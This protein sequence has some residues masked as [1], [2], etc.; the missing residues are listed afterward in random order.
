MTRTLIEHVDTELGRWLHAMR[1]PPADLAADVAMLW[2]GDGQTHYRR[3]RILPRG[4]VHLLINLGPRQFLVTAAGERI[5]FDDFWISG[6]QDRYL[7]TEAP[8]GACL[9]GVAFAPGGAWPYLPMP[10]NVLRGFNGE[11]AAVLGDGAMTLRQRLL[12][13]DDVEARFVLVEDWLRRQRRPHRVR[14]AA[15]ASALQAFSRAGTPRI[16]AL[17]RDCG[18]S[19]RRLGQLFDREVGLSPKVWSRL[20]RF[21]ACLSAMRDGIGSACELADRFGYADQAHMSREVRAFSGYAP[22]ELMA[23]PSPDAMTVVVA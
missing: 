4:C 19:E 13:R 1:L 11:M 14:H 15:V 12:E 20:V 22:S 10:Q 7:D 18:V 23:R 3:D 2:F 8:A 21:Q 17:A 6:I 5:P 9:L 16:A